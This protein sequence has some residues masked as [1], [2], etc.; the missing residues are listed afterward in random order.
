MKLARIAGVVGALLLGAVFGRY[1]AWVLGYVGE[2]GPVDPVALALA[3]LLLTSAGF[4]AAGWYARGTHESNA[5]R[6]RVMRGDPIA[7]TAPAAGRLNAS[8]PRLYGRPVDT[9]PLPRVDGP[10]PQCIT[11][12]PAIRLREDRHT[13]GCIWCPHAAPPGPA[14]GWR[15]GVSRTSAVCPCC[16]RGDR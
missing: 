6:Q 2:L 15:P 14:P 9:Q 1:V 12:P 3:A 10:A 16:F 13:T 8:V 5:R 4:Y 7:V 11:G